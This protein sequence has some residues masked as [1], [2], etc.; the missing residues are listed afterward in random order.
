MPRHDKWKMKI[1]GLKVQKIPRNQWP[2]APVRPKKPQMPPELRLRGQGGAAM[3]GEGDQE[4][5]VSS[6]D[7]G[8]DSDRD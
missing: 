2:K 8:N 7:N 4:G 1:E 3:T 5:S 6:S